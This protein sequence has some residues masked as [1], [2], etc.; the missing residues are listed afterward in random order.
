M[1]TSGTPDTPGVLGTVTDRLTEHSHT[2]NKY[3]VIGITAS[4]SAGMPHCQQ[5]Y[6]Y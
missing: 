5:V 6:Q 2:L 1:G 3:R 4:D